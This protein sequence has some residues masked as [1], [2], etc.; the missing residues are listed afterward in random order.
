MKTVHRDHEGPSQLMT[1]SIYKTPDGCHMSLI[2]QL[3]LSQYGYH[4]FLYLFPS[5]DTFV[6]NV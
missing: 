3:S 4:S 6:L 1:I 5:A 2:F